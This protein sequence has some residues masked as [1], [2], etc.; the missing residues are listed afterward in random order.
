MADDGTSAPTPESQILTA[1]SLNVLP[2][3]AAIR[4][5][6]GS[7]MMVM[8]GTRSF[9]DPQEH[10]ELRPL[11]AAMMEQDGPGTFICVP[12]EVAAGDRAV[13]TIV[14]WIGMGR[15]QDG[16]AVI[17]LEGQERVDVDVHEAGSLLVGEWTSR[18]DVPSLGLADAV[19]SA[20]RQVAASPFEWSETMSG[21]SDDGKFV[22]SFVQIALLEADA[23]T[24][25]LVLDTDDPVVRL[26]VASNAFD[27]RV[28]ELIRTDPF[29]N[30]KDRLSK[31]ELPEELQRRVER[32]LAKFKAMPEQHPE[33]RGVED[34]LNLVADLPWGEEPAASMLGFTEARAVLDGSHAGLREAK[35][36]VIDQLAQLRWWKEQ[37]AARP[38][39]ER[40]PAPTPQYL[41]FVGPKGTGKTS[42]LESIA[43]AAGRDFRLIDIGS[44]SSV[45]ELNGFAATYVGSQAGKIL[46]TIADARTS[47][48]VVGLDEI[49]KLKSGGQNG[50]P[51]SV[52]LTITDPSRNRTYTDQFANFPFDLSNVW[53]IATANELSQIPETLL[54]RFSIVSL[55][56][57]SPHE[58]LLAARSHI[59]P[60][61]YRTLNTSPEQIEI[62][63]AAIRK[64]IDEHTRES[65]FRGLTNNLKTLLQKSE[66]ALMDAQD[67]GEQRGLPLV[68]DEAFVD[69]ALGKGRT[70]D[71]VPLSGEPGYATVMFAMPG[72]GM[73][74]LG[75]ANVMTYS[76]GKGRLV[77][78]GGVKETIKESAQVALSWVITHRDQLGIDEKYD[79]AGHDYHID[80]GVN[81]VEKDGPSAGVALTVMLASKFLDEPVA[82]RLAM[83]GTITGDG[84]VG[85]IGGVVEKVLAAHRD[86]V[87]TVMIPV[88]NARDVDE[89]PQDVRDEVRIVP[90]SRIEEAL[91][92]AFPGKQFDFARRGPAREG[93]E[94]V[95]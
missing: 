34:F 7:P 88:A 23:Q 35:E 56:G 66:R 76:T 32:E 71:P 5:D 28:Q 14:T 94:A 46:K 52:L 59:L 87:R 90:V 8:P 92:I 49:D 51:Y 21:L 60:R 77:V 18:Q 24:K 81:G 72:L 62:T 30:L 9:L 41:L 82:P 75:A 38:E 45:G 12:S 50:D 73:G 27:A 33:R 70:V 78:T 55:R 83:T 10:P 39:A 2:V 43:K 4:Q 37:N 57:Y 64:V 80:F 89:I 67:S 36:R 53:F 63:D 20:R 1:S 93:L 91:Q 40:T 86:G 48:L 22:N 42:I 69:T 11:M 44:L 84:R 16:S 74:D 85:P 6:D 15:K 54:D 25:Q 13:G 68:V 58:K 19:A 79:F 17:V 29:L 3:A 26:S 95:A 47:N 61:L 65:G 31:R